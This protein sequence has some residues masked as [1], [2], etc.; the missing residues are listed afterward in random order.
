MPSNAPPVNSEQSQAVR[1][2]VGRLAAAAQRDD[3]TL[4][5]TRIHTGPPE[6]PTVHDKYPVVTITIR[7][8]ATHTESDINDLV[9]GDVK[10]KPILEPNSDE[11]H[12]TGHR[13]VVK[14]YDHN[15]DNYPP[16]ND[17][18]WEDIADWNEIGFNPESYTVTPDTARGTQ[19]DMFTMRTPKGALEGVTEQLAAC[20]DA[21]R[22]Y[23]LIN[24]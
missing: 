6:T 20:M 9:I 3:E 15:Y 19:S 22:E 4:T 10:V 2:T 23:R 12:Y 1:T 13:T 5:L 8:D 16:F 14:L 17:D 7:H 24:S 21:L 18:T 11:E